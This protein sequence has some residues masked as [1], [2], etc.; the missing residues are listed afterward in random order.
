MTARGNSSFQAGTR[1]VV[2]PIKTTSEECDRVGYRRFAKGDLQR[3]SAH[4][5]AALRARGT[6]PE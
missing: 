3:E 1:K 4:R 5:S 6:R 2:F